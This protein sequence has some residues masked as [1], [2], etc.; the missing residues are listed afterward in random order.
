MVS[1]VS[2]GFG[3]FPWVFVLVYF[4]RLRIISI[5]LYLFWWKDNLG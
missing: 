4:F 3:H 5:K 1:L 2:L